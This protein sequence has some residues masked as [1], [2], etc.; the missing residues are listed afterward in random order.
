MQQVL[1]DNSVKVQKPIEK[2]PNNT[3]DIEGTS[4]SKLTK[5]RQNM[6]TSLNANDIEGTKANTKQFHYQ[7]KDIRN[8]LEPIQEQQVAEAKYSYVGGDPAKQIQYKKFENRT[9]NPYQERG[10]G[11]RMRN[12]MDY[13]EVYKNKKEDM[14]KKDKPVFEKKEIEGTKAKPRTH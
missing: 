7:R 3:K 5:P 14:V 11:G 2:Q 12:S 1:Y 13:T 6:S 4:P 10:L 8:P 9:L